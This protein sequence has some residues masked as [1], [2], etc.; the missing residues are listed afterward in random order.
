MRTQLKI[1]TNFVRTNSSNTKKRRL[2]FM[3]SPNK[4]K[5]NM[6]ALM[7]THIYTYECMYAH[8]YIR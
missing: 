3:K 7:Y 5:T 4:Q 6:L 8:M 2:M 1:W